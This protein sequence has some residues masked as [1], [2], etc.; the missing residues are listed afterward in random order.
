[1]SGPIGRCLLDGLVRGAG[2]VCLSAK[3]ISNLSSPQINRSGW[4]R[5]SGQ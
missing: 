1:M 2:V 5:H 4:I 3:Q